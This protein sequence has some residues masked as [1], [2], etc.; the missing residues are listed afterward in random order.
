MKDMRKIVNPGSVTIR[1]FQTD[2]FCIIKICEGE[3][4]ASGVVGPLANGNCLGSAGQINPVEVDHYAEGWSLQLLTEFNEIWSRWHLN[5]ME[6]SCEHQRDLN[7]QKVIELIEF[8]WSKAYYNQRNSAEDGTMSQKSY[9]A[10]GNIVKRVTR[11]LFSPDASHKWESPEVKRLIAEGWIKKKG[12]IKKEACGW[13]R[14]SEHPE[15]LLCKPCE[16]C[17]YKY[18]T[19]WLKEELPDAVRCFVEELPLCHKI[20]AWC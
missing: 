14:Y 7:T 8:E 10:W 18:G 17:G 15:G 6:A 13:V 3:F 1:S 5:N 2:V 20:P 11:I 12:K 4:T 19:A 16:V 9:A